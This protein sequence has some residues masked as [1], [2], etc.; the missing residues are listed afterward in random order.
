VSKIYDFPLELFVHAA[1]EHA[2]DVA[3]LL[4]ILVLKRLRGYDRRRVN[5]LQSADDL[6]QAASV[7]SN[8]FSRSRNG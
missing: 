8:G 4:G 6:Q 2:R 3:V 7:R 1:P 5:V